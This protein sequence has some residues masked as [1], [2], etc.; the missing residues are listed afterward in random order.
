MSFPDGQP[1]PAGKVRQSAAAEMLPRAAA[2]APA[3]PLHTVADPK[4][5]MFCFQCEQ[6]RVGASAMFIRYPWRLYLWTHAGSQ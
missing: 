3:A 2:V 1:F 5:D 6:T 4:H